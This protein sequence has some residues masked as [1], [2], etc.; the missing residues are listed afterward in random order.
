MV[1]AIVER[2]ALETD[3]R[4]RLADER[5]RVE[6]VLRS[7]REAGAACEKHLGEAKRQDVMRSVTG[8]SSIERAIE[9]AQRMI[10]VIDRKLG[11][12]GG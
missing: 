7:L 9:E 4:R 5:E 8:S 1:R 11:A 3:E 10:D 6:A 2:K 12:G